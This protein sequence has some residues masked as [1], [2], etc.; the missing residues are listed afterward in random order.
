MTETEN[1]PSDRTDQPEMATPPSG[2]SKAVSWDAFL[3]T[4]SPAF[5]LALGAGI[6]LP[7]IP[8]L[9][10]SFDV[11]FGVAS[12][13]VT[14]FL[15]GNLAATLPSGWL[16]DR[17][18]RRPVIIAGPLLTAATSLLIVFAESFTQLL[19]LRFLAGCAA[20]MWLMA[21]L[22]AISHGAAAGERGR[23]IS[24]LFGMDSVGRLSGPML[25]GFIATAWDIRAAFVAYAVLALIALIPTVLFAE[26]TPR[27]AR[28]AKE[29]TR[30]LSLREIVLP[31]LP[32]FGVALFAGLARGPIYAGL[33]DLYAA[34]AYRLDPAQIAFLATG[35]IMINLPIAFAAGWMMDHFGRKRTMVPGFG[36]VAVSMAALAVCAF[37]PLSY[38]WYVALFFFA[39]TAQALTGSSI[40][41][42]GADVAPAEARGLFLG[43]WRLTG[44]GGVTL[45]PILFAVIAETLGYGS[46]FL[47]VAAAGAVVTFLLIFYVPETRTRG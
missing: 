29:K 13:V 34:F 42:V 2:V 5:L 37:I 40:Q 15:I 17:V 31:R 20:Q 38:A 10:Q 18:G 21:R 45:S 26:N 7:V 16:I 4:Y 25:G 46:S 14:S 39:V 30:R 6:V 27:H 33:L 9:A 11:S 35:A 28:Q 12:G 23:Q 22:A 19:V 24:W 47:F 32:Y 41:T 1:R 44:Q 8:A 3:S 36:G 43:V